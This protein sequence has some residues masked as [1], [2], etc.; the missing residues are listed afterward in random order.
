MIG[1]GV[2]FDSADVVEK[3]DMVQLFIN[4]GRVVLLPE[5]ENVAETGKIGS[6]NESLSTSDDHTFLSKSEENV[7][8][9]QNDSDISREKNRSEDDSGSEQINS[10]THSEDHAVDE[11]EEM[12][13]D[14][15]TSPAPESALQQEN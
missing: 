15:D 13:I 2:F 3:E 11:R 7:E 4:S 5:T 1:A 9:N 12:E 14:N 6:S 8:M 10:S